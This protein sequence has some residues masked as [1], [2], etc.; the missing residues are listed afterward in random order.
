MTERRSPSLRRSS[1]HGSRFMSL[2][3]PLTFCPLKKLKETDPQPGELYIWPRDENDHV[4][5]AGL[6]LSQ[7][8]AVLRQGPGPVERILVSDD[9]TFE[10]MLA[11]LFV[12]RRLAGE[13]LF[14]GLAAFARYAEIAHEGRRPD[15]LPVAASMEG[16]F[17]A[18]RA[19]GGPHLVESLPTRR[20]ILGWGR[21]VAVT[22]QAAQAGVDPFVTPL[23][24]T[25]DF[26]R[27]HVYL[28]GDE[29][30]YRQDV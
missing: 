14:P 28:A 22:L 27:E 7:G 23:F 16:V 17:L 30:L 8:E 26:A 25:S 5:M 13:E 10:D 4:G 24:A 18:I 6:V 11:A 19:A 21:L 3:L 1:F 12:Q 15:E 29:A 2:S 9:P 20:F